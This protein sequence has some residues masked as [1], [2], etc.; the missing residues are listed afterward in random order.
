MNRVITQTLSV[1]VVSV[2]VIAANTGFSEMQSFSRM[3]A[4]VDKSIPES[5]RAAFDDDDGRPMKSVSVDLN[6]DKNPE[7]LI[8]NEF[9]CGNGGCPWLVYSPSLNRVIGRV[10]GSTITVLDT[11]TEGFKSI[12]ITGSLGA[13]RRTSILYEFRDGGYS[14]KT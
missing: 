6:N 1:A 13:D 2:F 5:V 11:A 4:I 3:S 7:K 10:F 8:P 9:L 14:N 12:Q